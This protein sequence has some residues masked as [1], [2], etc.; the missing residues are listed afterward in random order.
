MSVT[1]GDYPVYYLS[2]DWTDRRIMYGRGPPLQPGQWGFLCSIWPGSGRGLLMAASQVA[3][4]HTGLELAAAVESERSAPRGHD[5][6]GRCWSRSPPASHHPRRGV[7][8][9][10][11]QALLRELM[12]VRAGRCFQVLSLDWCSLLASSWISIPTKGLCSEKKGIKIFFM[13]G[14]KVH[15]KIL[16]MEV[17]LH[18]CENPLFGL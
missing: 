4:G 6:G 11:A 13:L 18:C 14:K 12:Q 8:T 9:G 15:W 5:Q 7:R 3:L 17:L 16:E 2:S 10:A 1:S